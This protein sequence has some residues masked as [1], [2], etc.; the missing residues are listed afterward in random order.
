MIEEDKKLSN[1]F[2]SRAIAM[3]ELYDKTSD[4]NRLGFIEEIYKIQQELLKYKE[5]NKKCIKAIEINKEIVKEQPSDNEL[6]DK[7]V[8]DMLDRFLKFLE[9]ED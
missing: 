2:L 3:N 7:Y 5:A 4:Y 9:V 6:T 1:E 8:I